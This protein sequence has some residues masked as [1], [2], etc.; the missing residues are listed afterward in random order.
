[1]TDENVVAGAWGTKE[2]SIKVIHYT[3]TRVCECICVCV[4]VYI[5]YRLPSPIRGV[6]LLFRILALSL[7]SGRLARHGPVSDAALVLMGTMRRTGLVSALELPFCCSFT[8]ICRKVQV[9][10]CTRSSR[11][12]SLPALPVPAHPLPLRPLV[13][14]LTD[15]RAGVRWAAAFLLP[16]SPPL[17]SPYLLACCWK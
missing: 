8:P 3:G 15:H 16:P 4:C 14:N 11:T 2:T 9:L 6:Y 12:A 10:A 5:I 1:M 13:N 17:P 7:P